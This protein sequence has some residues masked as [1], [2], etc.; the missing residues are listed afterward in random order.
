MT[1]NPQGPGPQGPG[2]QNPYGQPG[3]GQPQPGYGQPP[4]QGQPPAGYPQPGQPGAYPPAPG[5]QQPGAY[6]PP[7][8][9]GQP[10][11]GQAPGYPPAGSPYGQPGAQVSI[12]DAFSYGWNKFTSNA[13][14]VIGGFLVWW[15][16]L[17][18]VVVVMSFVALGSLFAGSDSSGNLSGA[19]AFGFGA[20]TLLFTPVV[21]V[22]SYLVQAAMINVASV[23]STG[24]KV[25]FRDF[26]SFPNFGTVILLC[27]VI[28]VANG[29]LSF[30]YVGSLAVTLFSQFMLFFAIDQRQGFVD[31]F[32]NGWDLVVKNFTP[33]LLLMLVVL[34]CTFVGALACGLGLVV[35]VPVAMFTSAFVYRR[36]IGQQPA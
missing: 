10:P 21:M 6:P 16:I 7:P 3:P 32:R 22:V 2:P 34:A 19:G 4:A 13:G 36:L 1:D 35:G 30:T 25:E 20:G 8:Q 9:G 15:A 14:V 26:F 24:R 5:A 33:A 18:V 17:A 29:L 23:A 27:L 11:Y 31:A 28:G 12:G